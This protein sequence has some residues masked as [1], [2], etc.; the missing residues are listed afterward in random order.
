MKNILII[1]ITSSF[2]LSNVFTQSFMTN[3]LDRAEL[4][5]RSTGRINFAMQE[6][7]RAYDVRICTEAQG[8][9]KTTKWPRDEFVFTNTTFE[10]VFRT[11]MQA[12]TNLTWRYENTSDT[13]YIH[14]TTNALMMMRCGP[15]S[16]TNTPAY[17][18]IFE[19]DMLGLRT[20]GVIAIEYLSD[21][22][23]MNEEVSFEFEDAY[24]WEILD[25]IDSQMSDGKSWDI[26]ES[27]RDGYRYAFTFYTEFQH[28][29][30]TNIFDNVKQ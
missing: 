3:S 5:I 4:K 27:H 15:I 8:N 11:I 10:H 9:Y 25:V 14:P 2:V 26:F 12:T 29:L 21:L 28:Y 23:Y 20:N 22:G 13:I 24:V 17:N 16:V 18:V 7:S 19:D 30:K 6:V 1:A